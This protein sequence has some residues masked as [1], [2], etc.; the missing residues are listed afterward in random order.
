VD[1]V[2]GLQAFENPALLEK[3]VTANKE[4]LIFGFLLLGQTPSS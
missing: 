4:F 3:L 2:D 1:F